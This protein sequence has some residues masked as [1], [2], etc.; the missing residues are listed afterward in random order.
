[1]KTFFRKKSVKVLIAALVIALISALSISFSASNK[2]VITSGANLIL[3]PLRRAMNTV[4]NQFEHLYT[5]MYRYDKLEAENTA[6]KERIADMEEEYRGY[7]EV[8]SEN[9]R[10]RGLLELKEV[11]TDYELEA[12]VIESWSASNFESAFTI[13]RGSENGIELKDCV[14]D[15]FSNAVGMVTEVTETTAVVSTV[16]DTSNSM[17]AIVSETGDSG[18]ARGDFSRMQEKTLKLDYL[19]DD[20]ELISGFSV[21]TSGSSG[22]MP[23]GL[24]I[25]KITDMN[26]NSS[27]VGDYAVVTPA[28]DFGTL[29][30]VY[31]IT[32]FEG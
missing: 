10:L 5:Y 4:V 26:I 22:L 11:R 16:V 6:L 1:M 28:C 17:G 12:A 18:I 32:D 15:Q 24:L 7:S 31:I 23:K 14:I 3:Q 25:G 30:F 9:E 13:N 29:E 21:I 27:G 20:A 19:P 8:Y 2:D